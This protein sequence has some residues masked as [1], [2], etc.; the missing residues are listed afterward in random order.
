MK[1][2][3]Q[4]VAIATTFTLAGLMAAAITSATAQVQPQPSQQPPDSVVAVVADAQG[5]PFVPPDQRPVFGTFW[6]VRSSLPC[7]TAPLPFPP[8]DPATPVYAIGDSAAGGQF[9]VDQTAG[10]VVSPQA[11][12]GRRALRSMSTDSIL[13]AQAEKLQTFVA[14]VQ[15]RQAYAQLRANGQMSPLSDGPPTPGEGG[16]GGTNEW[17]GGI[18]FNAYQYTSNDLWLE[19]VTVTNLTG[20]FVVHPPEAEA[21]TGVYDLFMTTNLSPNVPGLNLTNWL[22]L[23]RTD[24]GETNLIVPDLWADQ[25]YFMLGRTNDTD[26]DGMSDAYEHLVSH[27]S[28]TNADAPVIIFQPLSQTVWA[29][30]T[31]T[32]TV[33]AE[34][35]QPLAYQWMLNTNVISGATNASLTLDSAMPSLEGDYSAVVTSPVGLSVL[36]SNATL[37]VQSPWGN[38]FPLSGPRQDFTFKAGFTYVITSPVQLY[39]RTTIQGGTVIKL[40]TWQ[41]STLQVMGTLI[42]DAKPYYPGILTC[43]DDDSAGEYVDWSNDS[44]A[45]LTNGMPY[46][47]LTVLPGPATVHQQPP[48]LLCRSSGCNSLNRHSPRYVGLPIRSMQHWRCER[49]HQH[50]CRRSPAQRSFRWVPGCRINVQHQHVNHGRAHHRRRRHLL[51]DA[52]RPRSDQPHKQHHHRHDGRRPDRRKRSLRHKSHRSRLSDERLRQ[53]LPHKREPVPAR[54]HGR[55]QF[56]PSCGISTEDDPAPAC[57][58]RIHEPRRRPEP[59]PASG[60]LY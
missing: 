49:Q 19:I 23:L 8:L 28:P 1:L 59:R 3:E 47:D 53:P 39:G 11:Q 51:G 4:A 50:P 7:I 44:P 37:S 55:N 57:I 17:G 34:G 2:S 30:D 14:Q 21:T 40:D 27:T 20:F 29:G 12:F 41:N 36:S 56:A 15:A 46:L 38:Y 5:L 35:A 16:S 9:L 33:V 45:M 26:G 10:Q 54:R 52:H 22:W 43:V 6:E 58:S 48:L 32:F 24:P 18:T 60:P 25:A 31:V 13:Q 42:T